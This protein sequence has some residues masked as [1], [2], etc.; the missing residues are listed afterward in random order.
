MKP[1]PGKQTSFVLRP[2]LAN[3]L[4]EA[5]LRRLE[6]ALATHVREINAEIDARSAKL[7]D[8]IRRAASAAGTEEDRK[9]NAGVPDLTNK[10][11]PNN[12]F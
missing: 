8:M 1:K 3:K 4:K 9:E 6:E 2:S 11:A 5:A 7:K 10:K 12:M